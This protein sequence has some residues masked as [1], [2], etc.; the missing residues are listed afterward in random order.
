M[1]QGRSVL[2]LSACAVVRGLPVSRRSRNTRPKEGLFTG[3]NGATVRI[4][5]SV[6]E[7][8]LV[9]HGVE[10]GTTVPVATSWCTACVME[11]AYGKRTHFAPANED[12]ATFDQALSPPLAPA[13][14]RRQL[15]CQATAISPQTA[16]IQRTI[17]GQRGRNRC[18]DSRPSSD[19]QQVN[20]CQALPKLKAKQAQQAAH[21][22]GS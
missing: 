15:D 19:L 20:D 13:R 14:N 22:L 3:A 5:N 11:G 4:G 18:V 10:D 21:P 17:L 1:L 12:C 2:R 16:W 6:R 7:W 8:S 9:R